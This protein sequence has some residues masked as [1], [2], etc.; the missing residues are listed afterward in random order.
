M[1][2]DD[3]RWFR[4]GELEMVCRCRGIRVFFDFNNFG[5]GVTDENWE[6]E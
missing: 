1:S 2:K 5:L 4:D 6:E 3:L